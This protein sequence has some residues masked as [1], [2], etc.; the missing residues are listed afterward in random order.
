MSAATQP[1]PGPAGRSTTGVSAAARPLG[2]CVAYLT[3]RL[4]RCGLRRVLRAVCV[5]DGG[6]CGASG[7]GESAACG[8]DDVRAVHRGG[9]PGHR[10]KAP[11]PPQHNTN[12]QLCASTTQHNTNNTAAHQPLAHL[13]RQRLVATARSA[14][15]CAAPRAGSAPSP[16]TAAGT[17][18]SHSRKR[19]RSWPRRPCAVRQSIICQT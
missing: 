19:R 13:P 1:A 8:G 5:R 11:L 14:S 17:P 2:V 10:V 16:R 6:G 15:C 3:K 12:T 9:Q 18:G 7:A 4:R